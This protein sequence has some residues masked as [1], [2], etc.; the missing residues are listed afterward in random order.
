MSWHD[1]EKPPLNMDIHNTA[2]TSRSEVFYET[3][4][5]TAT[6]VPLAYVIEAIL[7]FPRSLL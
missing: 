5:V 6:R 2:F 1:P 7:A 3:E 4:M